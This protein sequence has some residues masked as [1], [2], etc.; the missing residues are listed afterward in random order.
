M[1]C[2]YKLPACND[3]VVLIIADFCFHFRNGYNY[4]DDFGSDARCGSI[5][6]YL[7]KQLKPGVE[8]CILDGEMMPWNTKF[9]K[10]GNKG[11]L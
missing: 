4:T 1:T 11:I 3:S 6:P 7:T 9:K 2:V 5:S 8:S 10:F